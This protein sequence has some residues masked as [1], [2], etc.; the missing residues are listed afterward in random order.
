LK[1]FIVLFLILTLACFSAA[2]CGA[3]DK[4]EEKAAEKMTEEILEQAGAEDVDIDGDKVTLKGEDGEEVTFGGD[5]WPESD[6]ANSIPE[7]SKGEFANIMETSNYL[8]INFEEV[9]EADAAAYIE[10]NKPEF[11]L[12]NY[13][14]KSEGMISWSGRND[15]GLQLSLT[16]ADAS[17]TITLMLDES[18]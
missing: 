15:E 17:F 12:D 9:K 11:T 3:K 16:L 14:S 10:Q 2:G 1:K 5:E 4:L 7:F 8:M 6:L 13:E 18:E